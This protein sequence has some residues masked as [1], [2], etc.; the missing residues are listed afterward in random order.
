MNLLELGVGET[1][2]QSLGRALLDLAYRIVAPPFLQPHR[3]GHATTLLAAALGVL[4]HMAQIFVW[5]FVAG[6]IVY[7]L[8]VGARGKARLPRFVY[9]KTIGQIDERFTLRGAFKY[10]LPADVYRNRSFWVDMFWLPFST[11]LNFFGLAGLVMGTAL[12]QGWLQQH[13]GHS[14]LSIPD[15]LF[16]VVLQ[17]VI[18]LVARDFG[19]YV[20]HIQGHTIPFF[21]EFHK[22]H[23]SAEV[24]HPFHVRT[25]PVD[26]FIRNTYIAV[27][28]GLISGAVIYLLGMKFSVTTAAWI[29]IWGACVEVL[30]LPEH[31]HVRLSFGK[32]LDSII[33]PPYLHHFHH[34]AKPEHMN[35]NLGLTGGLVLWDRLFGTYYNPKPGEEVVWGASLEELGDRNPHRTLW[36]F[37][38]TPFV[39]A[40]RTLRPRP[41]AVDPRQTLPTGGIGVASRSSAT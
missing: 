5:F 15:G 25:H 12:V 21:W 20:W 8:S 36:G 4:E 27:G 22:G 2:P 35:V 7:A 37:F 13:L 17:V 40:F 31:S 9:P 39:E 32:F 18:V 10:L 30:Q 14:P 38:F 34:G 16:A 19:H 33:Y 6:V 28:G 1:A 29:A 3:A 41:A 11:I 26:M 23:H 24:L